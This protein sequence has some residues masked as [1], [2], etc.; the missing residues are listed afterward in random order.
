MFLAYGKGVLRAY[1]FRG[2]TLRTVYVRPPHEEE[3]DEEDA[4]QVALGINGKNGSVWLGLGTRLHHYSQQGELLS[5][6]GLDAPVRALAVDQARGQVWVATRKTLAAYDDAA[7]PVKAIPLPCDGSRRRCRPSA[8]R[9][10]R[11]TSLTTAAAAMTTDKK[12][13]FKAALIAPLGVPLAITFAAAWESVS[14]FGLSGLRDLPVAALFFFIFGLPI[15]EPL[16]C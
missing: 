15:R 14:L 16:N 1:D 11:R 9:S 3:E 10:S 8:A 12:P 4:S 7:K 6:S 2:Q 5:N 13:I